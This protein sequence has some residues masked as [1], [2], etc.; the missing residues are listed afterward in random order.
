MK[1]AASILIITVLM[2]AG[3][4]LPSIADYYPGPYDYPYIIKYTKNGYSHVMSTDKPLVL[5]NGNYETTQN[6]FASYWRNLDKHI[7]KWMYE[8]GFTMIACNG[9]FVLNGTIG[10]KS[11][12]LQI[13]SDYFIY[14]TSELSNRTFT[15]NQTGVDKTK[16]ITC[17]VTNPQG[18]QSTVM[19]NWQFN[20]SIISLWQLNPNLSFW[21]EGNYNIYVSCDGVYD[22]G[23]FTLSRTDVQ[24]SGTVT[25][26][27]GTSYTVETVKQAY[28]SSPRTGDNKTGRFYIQIKTTG[29]PYRLPNGKTTY[30]IYY[31]FQ[32]NKLINGT[33]NSDVTMTNKEERY[34]YSSSTV[35]QRNLVLYV[36]ENVDGTPY[37]GKTGVSAKTDISTW[38]HPESGKWFIPIDIV[39]FNYGAAATIEDEATGNVSP[40]QEPGQTAWEA[41]VNTTQSGIEYTMPGIKFD[42]D[43]VTASIVDFMSGFS[44]FFSVI[45]SLF[46]FIPPVIMGMAITGATLSLALL[47][48]RK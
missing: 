22:A 34:W 13:N 38:Q 4:V 3:M 25:D 45:G 21:T 10:Y 30:S 18:V 14:N 12:T 48:F 44:S 32:G 46:S 24:D 43:S 42:F 28:I 1:K 19:Q 15:V 39:S 8:T 31:Y 26:S 47:I 9:D 41:I 27:N 37:S 40:W 36:G 16:Q 2:V 23:V 6:T 35:G 11:L 7:D 29:Q 20:S 5:K 17:T 33:L